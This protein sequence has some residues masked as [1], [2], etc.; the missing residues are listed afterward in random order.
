MANPYLNLGCGKTHFPSATPPPGHELVDP[1][2]Y[3]YPE[4]LNVD[5]VEG[6]GAD[7]VFDLFAYPWPLASNSYDGAILAHIAEHIPHGIELTEHDVD[8]PD[9]Q[10]I[11]RVGNGWFDKEGNRVAPPPPRLQRQRELHTMQDGWYAFMAELWRVLTPGSIVHI[12]SPYAWTDGAMV[13]P[14]HTRYLTPQSFMH[15]LDNGGDGGATFKYNVGC[16]F[17]VAQPAKFRVSPLFGHLL[18]Q[19]QDDEA[20]RNQKANAFTLALMTQINVVYD[21]YMQL[22]AVKP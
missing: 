7:K 6:V 14:T 5:K 11:M 20:T 3:H 8:P 2:I 17:R 10:G 22:E 21:F 4:Y 16:N 18:V 12:V 15:A 1:A 19:E 9:P 13:D